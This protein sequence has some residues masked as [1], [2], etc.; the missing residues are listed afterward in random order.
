MVA[1]PLLVFM[2]AYPM[3]FMQQFSPRYVIIAAELSPPSMGF[4]VY[5]HGYGPGAG[6]YPPPQGA[7]PPQ[8][9]YPAPP[10]QPGYAPPG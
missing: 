3:Y 7:Y 8:G 9:L 1:L 10:Q 4:P 2:R 5:P 6:G